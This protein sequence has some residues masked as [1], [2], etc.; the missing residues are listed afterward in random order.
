MIHTVLFPLDIVPLVFESSV[1]ICI[2]SMSVPQAPI[3][4]LTIVALFESIAQHDGTIGSEHRHL[5]YSS[6]EFYCTFLFC[7]VS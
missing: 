3:V 5:H 2:Y 7:L 4:G 6:Q 1:G